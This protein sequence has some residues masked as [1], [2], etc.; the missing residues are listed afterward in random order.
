MSS[1]QQQ[2]LETWVKQKLESLYLNKVDGEFDAYFESVFAPDVQLT[3]NDE[4]VTREQFKQDLKNFQFAATSGSVD[5]E[6]IEVK[7]KDEEKP[8]DVS[9]IEYSYV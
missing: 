6:H 2:D 4:S 3:V 1:T 8:N 9:N 7:P 5:W